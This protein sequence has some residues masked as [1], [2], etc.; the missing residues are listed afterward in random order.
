MSVYHRLPLRPRAVAVAGA[1]KP[2]AAAAKS[3]ASPDWGRE[4]RR[5]EM[6]HGDGHR[7]RWDSSLCDPVQAL[8]AD[9][10]PSAR[11]RFVHSK[12]NGPRDALHIECCVRVVTS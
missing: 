8:L 11:T 5:V 4:A 3:P 2:V 1:S 6:L 10:A 9:A 12:A 7:F